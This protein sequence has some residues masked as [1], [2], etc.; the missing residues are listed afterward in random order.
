M[1]RDLEKRIYMSAPQS[2]LDWDG[3]K[4]DII[5]ERARIAEVEKLLERA[6]IVVT[7]HIFGERD[8]GRGHTP[9]NLYNGI[10]F[11]SHCGDTHFYREYIMRVA[12]TLSVNIHMN[13]SNKED[14]YTILEQ[15]VSEYMRWSQWELRDTGLEVKELGQIKDL[16]HLNRGIIRMQFDITVAYDFRVKLEKVPEIAGIEGDIWFKDEY[17]Q[18]L[19]PSKKVWL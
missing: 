10:P 9:T 12:A 2:I 17:N 3:N 18:P 8:R 13:N 5:V 1:P 4:H 15:S 11:N 6:P 16:S 19:S 7:L 14:R